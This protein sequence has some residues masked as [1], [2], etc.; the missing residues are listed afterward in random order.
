MYGLDPGRPREDSSPPQSLGDLPG[1]GDRD[2]LPALE[3]QARPAMSVTLNL[4]HPAVRWVLIGLSILAIAAVGWFLIGRLLPS[5]PSGPT[6]SEKTSDS[7]AITKPIDQA[8]IDSLDARIRARALISDQAEAGAR[9]AQDRANRVKQ[10]AD[11]L[12]IAREWEGA[13]IAR[14][15][16]ADSLRST[17]AKKDI[18]IL[19]LKADTVDLRSQ[20]GI[21]NKRLKTTEDVNVGLRKD[22]DQA[23]QCKIAHFI[24]CPS[25]IQTAAMTAVIYF[26]ADRY[27]RR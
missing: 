3:V 27:Q 10:R 8:L 17:V 13:Y 11:S 22:L 7:L 5:N 20:L 15:E 6:K 2:H 24:N 9:V 25:R 12:A 1:R 23:R 19:G 4:K 26:A 18:V 16:E 14:T 21:V